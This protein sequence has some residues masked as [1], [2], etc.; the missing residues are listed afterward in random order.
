MGID[1]TRQFIDSS[2][3][4]AGFSLCRLAWNLDNIF[5]SLLFVQFAGSLTL[6]SL[7]IFSAANVLFALSNTT[8][9]ILAVLYM[10]FAILYG[11]YF[12][13]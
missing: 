11:N 9:Q 13:N 8:V 4:E 5:G 10:C 1:I 2:I 6:G 12:T 3:I 7:T